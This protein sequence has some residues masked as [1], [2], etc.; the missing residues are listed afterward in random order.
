MDFLA[1]ENG[2]LAVVNGDFVLVSGI[3]ATVQYLTQSLKLFL[4]EWFLDETKGF[5]WFDQVFIKNPNPAVLDSV[6]KK[7]I[8]DLPGVIELVSFDLSFLPAQRTLTITG[9][10][11][12]LDGEA[13]FTVTNIIPG[14]A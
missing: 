14:G 10:I 11:R 6:F 12:G 1:D 7:F 9:Q 13:D 3:D 5:P 8:I 4:G 2:D